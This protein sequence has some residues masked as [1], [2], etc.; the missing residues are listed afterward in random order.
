MTVTFL[1]STIGRVKM[2]GEESIETH[3]FNIKKIRGDILA[4]VF[5]GFCIRL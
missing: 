5:K 3:P 1:E 4:Q 2:G